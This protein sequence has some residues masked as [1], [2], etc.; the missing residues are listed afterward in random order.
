MIPG[1]PDFVTRILAAVAIVIGAFMLGQCQGRSAERTA[2]EA[3]AAAI[4]AK[5]VKIQ[6]AADDLR[7]KAE[8]L[9]RDRI[10]SNRKEVDDALSGIPDQAPTAR[11]RA[12]ACLELRRQAAAAG[13]PLPAC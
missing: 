6:R 4:A 11:Q 7:R 2:W 10:T 5:A 12:R 8:Q 13:K 9:D 1:V 3:K